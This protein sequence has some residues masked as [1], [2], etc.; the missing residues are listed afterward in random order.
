V[1]EEGGIEREK[2][3][4]YGWELVA[5]EDVAADT[6]G[7]NA[8]REDEVVESKRSRPRACNCY[9]GGQWMCST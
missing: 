3:R 6:L 1:R 8:A 7:D 9:E 4:T 5:D 2:V